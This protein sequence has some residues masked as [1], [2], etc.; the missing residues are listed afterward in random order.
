VLNDWAGV[1][2]NDLTA[3]PTIPAFNHF[4]RSAPSE[5]QFLCERTQFL[6]PMCLSDAT[7]PPRLLQPAG[8]FAQAA[9][10]AQMQI[11]FASRP[12]LN[13]SHPLQPV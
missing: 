6:A 4:W 9:A 3:H 11:T 1:P 2:E 13:L 10:V 8:D 5:T 12:S 7:A